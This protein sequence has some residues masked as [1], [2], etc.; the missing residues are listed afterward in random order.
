VAQA[1]NTDL[2]DKPKSFMNRTAVKR[3]LADSWSLWDYVNQMKNLRILRVRLKPLGLY[4]P[5]IDDT[6][7]GREM[8]FRAQLSTITLKL[9]VFDAEIPWNRP[10]G[11][12]LGDDD[13]SSPFRIIRCPPTDDIII[14]YSPNCRPAWT[15]CCCT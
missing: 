4:V 5:P 12:G 15:T 11:A 6:K 13:E 3:F 10:S 9:D 7:R 8:H 2:N 1:S 14:E